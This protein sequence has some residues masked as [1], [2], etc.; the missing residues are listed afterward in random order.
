MI[1][2]Y[3]TDRLGNTIRRIISGAA[4]ARN[5]RGERRPDRHFSQTLLGS[6][7]KVECE[8]GSR[9]QSGFTKKQIKTV[10]DRRLQLF[11]QTGRQL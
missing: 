5:P 8:Q 2:A 7:Y 11:D 3:S 6:Y 9:F 4:H 10:H 1:V